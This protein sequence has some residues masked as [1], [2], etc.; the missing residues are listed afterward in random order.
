ML[1]VLKPSWT[2]QTTRSARAQMS[3]VVADVVGGCRNV[4]FAIQCDRKVNPTLNSD[5]VSR[6]CQ[7]LCNINISL[8]DTNENYASLNSFSPNAIYN[9]HYSVDHGAN[10]GR[11]ALETRDNLIRL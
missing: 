3:N 7:L 4:F 10:S 1:E 5:H 11:L 2:E 6:W 8:L 9:Y